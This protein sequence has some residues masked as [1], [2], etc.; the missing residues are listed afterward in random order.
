MTLANRFSFTPLYHSTLGFENLFN[1]VER[2]LE[3]T[4]EKNKSLF[5]TTQY[6]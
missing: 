4:T 2:M 1:E 3:A 6:R 5:S